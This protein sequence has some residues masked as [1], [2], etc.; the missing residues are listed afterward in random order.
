MNKKLKLH[1]DL[2]S[3]VEF[4]EYW[5]IDVN[6]SIL[7]LSKPYYRNGEF[8]FKTSQGEYPTVFFEVET[9]VF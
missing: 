8:H 9:I 6:K 5:K 1:P 7:Q 4:L 3:N 2:I